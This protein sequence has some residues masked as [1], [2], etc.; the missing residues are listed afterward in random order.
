MK[1]ARLRMAGVA[2]VAALLAVLVPVTA[3]AGGGGGGG[4]GTQT[5]TFALQ[6]E[7]HLWTVPAHTFEATFEVSGAQGGQPSAFQGPGGSATDY[8]LGGRVTAT[9]AVTPGEVLQVN[10]GGLGG[11]G[12]IT[13][14]QP[15]GGF[16]GGGD[17]GTYP[18][19]NIEDALAWGPGGGGASDV[20][21]ADLAG[22]YDLDD[23]IL[24][25]GGGG[26]NAYTTVIFSGVYY[27]L[28]GG[29]G[30]QNGTDG[31]GGGHSGCNENGPTGVPN[32]TG[33]F[34]GQAGVVAG[35]GGGGG[36]GSVGGGGG[37]GGTLG[38]GGDGGSQGVC[39]YNQPAVGG[40]GGGGYYGGGGGGGSSAF[41]GSGGGGG[42]SNFGP[43]GSI[44]ESDVQAGNGLVRVTWTPQ[45]PSDLPE[46]SD[47]V[48]NDEDGQTDFPDD[49]QCEGPEDDSEE[50]EGGDVTP[51]ETQITKG[52]KSKTKSKKATF[53]F[54]GTDAAR[55]RRAR[56]SLTFECSLD[57]KAFK[58]CVSPKSYDGLK[59]GKHKFEVRA[60]DEAGNEDD[61]PAK[62]SWKIKK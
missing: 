31:L 59:K 7:P 25:G 49:L 23:R 55:S 10:V 47:E 53:E 43:T 29:G 22:D 13:R 18:H 8:G 39:V 5:R 26:G 16:N 58:A 51:P 38:Q 3:Q 11:G 41:N 56:G 45:P 52:P 2:A 54:D 1:T 6:P 40:G 4:G 30:G 61:S 62:D 32:G 17:G 19:P 21:R 36:G 27:G 57:G 9:I 48:D 35:P 46:C 14:S 24:V 37:T 33:A 28:G 15:T 12:F 34:G 42:G 50:E 44:F 20:R 60:I